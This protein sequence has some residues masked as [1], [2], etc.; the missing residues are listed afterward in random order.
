[1]VA[2]F[3]DLR[4]TVFMLDYKFIAENLQAVMANIADRFMKADAEAVARLYAR[5]T[6][7]TTNTQ[8]LQ[9]KRNANAEAMKGKSGKQPLDLNQRNILI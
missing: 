4:Y 2:Q 3:Y 8:A 7:L 6:E 9:Q 5:R 1:M